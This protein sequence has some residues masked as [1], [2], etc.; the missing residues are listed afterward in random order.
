MSRLFDY[1]RDVWVA[2]YFWWHLALSDLRSR[3]RGS[4]LGVFWSF[5]QPLGLTLLVSFVFS[6]L[7]N[8]NMGEYAPYILSG[9]IVWDYLVTTAVGGAVAFVQADAYIKQTR[10]PLAIYTLRNVIAGL[11]VLCLAS[12][13]LVM[14]ILITAPQ[15]AGLSWFAALAALPLIALLAWPWATIMAYVGTRFRD[16]PHALTLILQ[17]MWFISPIYFEASMFRNGG[18]DVLLDYNPVFHVLELVRAPM[19]RGE[20]PT[21]MNLVW[22]LGSFMVL[23]SI[24]ILIGRRAEDRVIFYL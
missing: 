9:L 17:A 16:L 2:R 6:K 5:L 20:L 1:F 18:L 11:I 24:A 22:V 15:R 7:L 8:T 23:S 21:I 12:V 10:H 13:G 4:V 14:W 19:L 3:W